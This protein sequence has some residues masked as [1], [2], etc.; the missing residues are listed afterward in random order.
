MSRTILL[1]LIGAL[2][3]CVGALASCSDSDSGASSTP[4]GAASTSGKDAKQ[5]AASKPPRSAPP[6]MVWIPAGEYAM[7]GNDPLARADELPRHKVR[8][9]GFF[10]DETEVTNEEF[11]RFADATDYVTTA[12][13]KP[14]W[15]ELKKQLPAGTPKPDDS[16]L[17]PASLVFTPPDH[18]VQLDDVSK[19]WSWMPGANWKHPLGPTTSIEGHERDPVVH[20]SWDDAVA[21]AAW[22]GKRLPTEAEWEWAARGGIAD[23][24]HPWGN[25]PVES[26][27]PKANVWQ[28]HFP[29]ENTQR[30]GFY[31]VAPV[32]SFAPNGYGL[33]DM[34]GNVWEWCSDWYRADYYAQVNQPDGI[35]NPRGPTDSLDPQEPHTPK[36]VHRGGSFLCH[37]VYCAS[38]RVSARMKSSPDSGLSHCGFRCVKSGSER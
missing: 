38:Y 26:G 25:E 20:V 2:A 37:E 16:M 21:Y 13:K 31:G 14:D 34:A 7:G 32:R 12:E 9:D 27:T 23:A 22:A 5:S 36:R 24:T 29:D 1:V 33:F 10:M 19:W 3:C 17:V 15:E 18:A 8:V 30:D 6:G 11:A 28:G 35:A 4:S